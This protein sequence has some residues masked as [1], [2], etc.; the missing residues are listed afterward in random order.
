MNSFVY[1]SDVI[2]IVTRKRVSGSGSHV[3]CNNHAAF[4]DPLP[5]CQV[6][7]QS[8]PHPV[9]PFRKGIHFAVWAFCILFD[10]QLQRYFYLLYHFCSIIN[11][12][13][14][15]LLPNQ[16]SFSPQY[17]HLSADSSLT[18]RGLWVEVVEIDSGFCFMISWM[19]L[20]NI[21]S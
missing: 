11:L 10:R 5:T 15:W 20:H 12:N 18:K 14:G 8:Y 19:P 4:V 2:K 9:A 7:C 6:K 21:D 17:W 3:I 16:T 13:F 1:L